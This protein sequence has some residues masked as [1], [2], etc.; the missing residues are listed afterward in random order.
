MVGVLVTRP[1]PDAALSAAQLGQLGITPVVAPLLRRVGL[2][3][4]LPK[5]DGFSALALTSANALR[6]LARRGVAAAYRHLPAFTVGDHTAR[7]ARELGFADVRSAGGRL[8]D[9]VELLAHAGIGGPVLYFAGKHLSGDLAK[10]LAP[11]ALPVTTVRI[12]DMVPVDG[13]PAELVE[14][15]ERDE[16]HAAMLYSRRTAQAFVDLFGPR[17]SRA[18]HLKL[19]MLCLSEKVAEPLLGNHF[20]RISLA[21]RVDDEAMMSLALSFAREHNAA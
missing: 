11:Y 15:I 21:D 12:Y 18:A 7:E 16:I 8:G 13:V 10:S 6:E 3:A 9:L 2:L 17:L 20:V 4:N 14:R 19:A 1:E 5:P